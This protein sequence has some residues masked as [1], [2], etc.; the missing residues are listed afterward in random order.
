[1]ADRDL[2]DILHSPLDDPESPPRWW[3]VVAGIVAGGLVVIA[4]YVVAS[5]GDGDPAAAPTP[6]VPTTSSTQPPAPEPAAFPPGYQPITDVI[7]GKPLYAIEVD[8]DLVVAVG[9][10]SRRGLE[11]QGEGLA[12]GSW[13]LETDAGDAIPSSAVVF[14]AFLDG[15]FSVVFPNPGDV[16]LRTMRLVEQW[17]I[18]ARSGTATAAVPGLPGPAPESISVALGGGV[19]LIVDGLEITG[20]AASLTWRL[21][22]A[23]A[24]TDVSVRLRPQADGEDVAEYFSRVD[25]FLGRQVAEP[26]SEGEIT[27]RR[28][29]DFPGELA[30]A[31]AV[32]VDADVFLVVPI[33][34][35]AAWDVSELPI[36]SP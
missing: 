16:G 7:G 25:F 6:A 14:D 1:M 29:E 10:A 18:D 8:D 22:G 15:T 36:V 23:D 3:P 20:I 2:S 5:R 27:F 17:R 13:V 33:P 4:A 28:N 31:S 19:E 9:T 34:A 35:A 26:T 11:S 30:D 12:G 24:A 21:A 32:A